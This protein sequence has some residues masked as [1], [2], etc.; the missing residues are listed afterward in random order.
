[1]GTNDVEIG[2]TRPQKIT[3]CLTILDRFL[4]QSH[5]VVSSFVMAAKD[6]SKSDSGKKINLLE[7]IANVL[8]RLIILHLL[9]GTTNYVFNDLQIIL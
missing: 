6:G 7:A 2:G 4:C 5:P 8:G 3:S 1:M 9:V